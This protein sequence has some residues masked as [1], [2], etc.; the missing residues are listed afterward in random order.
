V[1]RHAVDASEVG[2]LALFRGKP[3]LIIMGGPGSVAAAAGAG[4]ESTAMGKNQ[5]DK[6][7][8]FQRTNSLSKA[9]ALS[10]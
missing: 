6:T 3:G 10:E 8:V 5:N 2:Q 9:R 7:T 1:S 4:A